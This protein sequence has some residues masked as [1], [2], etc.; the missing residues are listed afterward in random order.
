M[1][2]AYKRAKDRGL[3]EVRLGNIGVF[4]STEE[5]LELLRNLP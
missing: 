3:E 4:V 1:L 5:E 2:E